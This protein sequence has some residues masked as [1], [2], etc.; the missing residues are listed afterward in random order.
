MSQKNDY[1]LVIFPGAHK[2]GTTLLQTALTANRALL[3]QHRMVLVERKSFYISELCAYLRNWSHGQ[4]NDISESTA[5]NSM[6]ELCGGNVDRTI[7]ISIEN[8]FGEFGHKPRMYQA[9]RPVLSRLRSILPDHA[10][11]VAYY[12]RKQDS[13]FESVYIQTVQKLKNWNFDEFFSKH[14]NSDLR[15]T[16]ILEEIS[17]FT[18]QENLIVRPFESIR[19]GQDAFVRELFRII[20]PELRDTADLGY[21]DR[22]NT[23][24]SLSG[25]ALKMAS[26]MFPML[27]TQERRVLI[28]FL[29][30]R[31]GND[32]YPKA[33]L[34]S[35]ERR[36]QLL[37]RVKNDN[38]KL[39][40]GYLDGQD[41]S[42]AY[43]D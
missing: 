6:R 33:S 3:E 23:N 35:D 14:C 1:K 16:P 2:T 27:D 9:V 28:R 17:E 34:L 31:F 13:F 42:E 38:A 26:V 12:V 43:R 8:L 39:A 19:A 37:A 36:E 4:T 30:N 20:S 11:R 21:L 41:G 5:R 10:M 15:W 7:I 25:K 22:S 32:K 40:R 18:G 29:Q 24:V